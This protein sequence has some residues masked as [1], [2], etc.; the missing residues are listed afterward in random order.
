MY[1]DWATSLIHRLR[2]LVND[3]M[4]R[5]AIV[6]EKDLPKDAAHPTGVAENLLDLRSSQQL[7]RLTGI[8]LH[9]V[10]MSHDDV[11]FFD[12]ICFVR[13]SLVGAYPFQMPCA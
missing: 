12:E 9:H 6:F 11:C 4:K 8:P 2:T 10:R 3:H 13:K 5:T 1:K 7:Q